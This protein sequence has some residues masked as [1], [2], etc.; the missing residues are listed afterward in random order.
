MEARSGVQICFTLSK[1]GTVTSFSPKAR[2][3]FSRSKILGVPFNKLARGLGSSFPPK[4]DIIDG[5]AVFKTREAKIIPGHVNGFRLRDRRTNTTG[6]TAVVTLR[7]EDEEEPHE[8]Q[9]Y[10]LKKAEA[11]FSNNRWQ[12]R[13]FRARKMTH[14]SGEDEYVLDYFADHKSLHAKG[15][16]RIKDC[17]VN[18]HFQPLVF[19]LHGTG[20]GVRDVILKASTPILRWKWAKSI[21]KLSR[22]SAE[23]KSIQILDETALPVFDEDKTQGRSWRDA[24]GRHSGSSGFQVGDLGRIAI[25]SARRRSYT[26]IHTQIRSSFGQQAQRMNYL[27]V[28]VMSCRSL[29]VGNSSTIYSKAYI[30]GPGDY[31]HEIGATEVGYG[32][33]PVFSSSGEQLAIE[34]KMCNILAQL[35]IPEHLS[36]DRCILCVEV[37][38]VGTISEKILGRA[39]VSLA[40]LP[41]GKYQYKWLTLKPAGQG[42]IKVG[43]CYD[44]E[45]KSPQQRRSSTSMI[46]D[47]DV[48]SEEKLTPSRGA[49][50]KSSAPLEPFADLDK[51][52]D[53]VFND[54]PKL[55]A[56]LKAAEAEARRVRDESHAMKVKL[57]NFARTLNKAV[58]Q[59]R[60]LEEALEASKQK[61]SLEKKSMHADVDKYKKQREE[62]FIANE[63]LKGD[64][65]AAKDG[66]LKAQKEM[67][68]RLTL[69]KRLY[70]KEK[71]GRKKAEELL[72]NM[73]KKGKDMGSD[74]VNTSKQKSIEEEY[75][76]SL[77]KLLE[78]ATTAESERDNAIQLAKKLERAKNEAL[79]TSEK[80]EEEATAEADK[81]RQEQIR[82]SEAEKLLEESRRSVAKISRESQMAQA[83]FRKIEAEASSLQTENVKCH[84]LIKDIELE[85]QKANEKLSSSEKARMEAFNAVTELKRLTSLEIASLKEQLVTTQDKLS[86]AQ[87]QAENWMRE[88]DATRRAVSEGSNAAAGRI[89]SLEANVAALGK[90][91][92]EAKAALQEVTSDRDHALEKAG[93]LG[94]ENE[95][96]RVALEK[97]NLRIEELEKQLK[98]TL[99]SLKLMK[100]DSL[101]RAT[102]IDHLSEELSKSKLH[103]K[104]AIDKL[105][106]LEKEREL[107]IKAQNSSLE[108][109]PRPLRVQIE[110]YTRYFNNI[111]KGND[112]L[113]SLGILPLKA[114]QLLSRL[115]SDGLL[116]SAFL[117]YSVPNCIDERVLNMPKKGAQLT[118]E[119]RKENLALIA[120]TCQS[121]GIEIGRPVEAVKLLMDAEARPRDSIDFLYSLVSFQLLRYVRLER[122]PEVKSSN[123]K[124]QQLLATNPSALLSEWVK[125][126][127]KDENA[128][129]SASWASLTLPCSLVG[130]IVEEAG[131]LVTVLPKVQ[132]NEVKNYL[133]HFG[134]GNPRYSHLSTQLDLL[135]V[136]WASA[137]L[138]PNRIREG[139]AKSQDQD[140]FKHLTETWNRL[141]LLFSAVLFDV[142]AEIRKRKSVM[143][144]ST[145]VKKES[146]ES[147]STMAWINNLGLKGQGRVYDL[148]EAS[149]DGLLLLRLLD[150]MAPG[151]VNWRKAEKNPNMEIKRMS[152]CD[153]AVKIGKEAPFYFSLVG[154]GGI[155]IT[156]G[157]RKLTMSLLWQMRR[158]QLLKFLQS[159]FKVHPPRRRSRIRAGGT[160]SSLTGQAT[161]R[162]DFKPEGG[163]PLATPRKSRRTSSMVIAGGN[164]D[165][166]A[167][168]DWANN[169]VRM[170]IKNNGLPKG[171][172]NLFGE[173]KRSVYQGTR[174]KSLHDPNLATSLF[175]FLLLWA[176]KPWTV[177]WKFVLK[178]ETEEQRLLNARY[179]ITIARKTGASIFVTPSDL[180]EVKPEM[181]LVFLGALLGLHSAGNPNDKDSA[182]KSPSRLNTRRKSLG[183]NLSLEDVGFRM[184]SEPDNDSDNEQMA[185]DV[186]SPVARLSS[187]IH[188][189]PFDLQGL[190]D[191]TGSF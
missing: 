60:L 42:E 173:E 38:E 181:S 123:A 53:A 140:N 167:V 104:D 191:V 83:G 37:I 18:L 115:G 138:E 182:P 24:A 130:S 170:A 185:N 111:L 4:G 102:E 16:I 163:S 153:L 1:D 186:F 15:S 23:T 187:I 143:G 147:A 106:A 27:C 54:K 148:V 89:G 71:A 141:N 118:A 161:P 32:S 188:T 56:K 47:E 35:D 64:V 59:N 70:D 119:D 58:S 29:L 113:R 14:P 184:P 126:T 99:D 98:E 55:E 26:K 10:L 189:N 135:G 9:G 90:Q 132:A 87:S 74:K 101:N 142:M 121:I 7:L 41:S 125:F 129:L 88:L 131:P 3:Y 69:A 17:K 40:N 150:S 68:K 160:P 66:Q 20:A 19:V 33:D 65:R 155:D 154:V 152:N 122:A 105:Q 21:Y 108:A 157:N 169:V 77:K 100:E 63:N 97:A 44:G 146:S 25:R 30:K 107:E 86:K 172:E 177:D 39:R 2:E 158:Y 51:E 168:V 62:L 34:R 110:T 162:N 166:N 139:D 36:L 127:S 85:I 5:E 78:R 136:P 175:Y 31:K 103:A 8:I 91:L 93:G 72:E 50:P 178:G 79:K 117:N 96:L 94:S 43:I 75:S 52:F 124:I 61:H 76:K 81:R 151:S 120:R 174:I 116:I 22:H 28:E 11:T 73:E 133:L 190:T 48:T 49:R 57:E 144:A 137:F 156:Q 95:R 45:Q 149:R 165:E 109:L 112:S 128:S 134:P 183:T 67:R 92:R 164:F 179:A 180:V 46:S 114:S 82:A 159:I 145:D 13:Y 6:Y 84:E 80:A 12:K 171:S 176:A